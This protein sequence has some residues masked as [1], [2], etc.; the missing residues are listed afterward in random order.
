MTH[1]H[2]RRART[3]AVLLAGAFV[4]AACGDTEPTADEVTETT[5][6]ASDPADEETTEAAAEGSVAFV[7]PEDGATVTSPVAIE[8]SATGVEVQPAAQ[9]VEGAGHLHVMVD[10]DCLPEGEVI[11][12][13]EQHVHF[14]DGSLT[15]ELELEAGEHT[16]CLQYADNDHI[17]TAITSTIT[18]TVE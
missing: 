9:L 16:L 15:G 13:D 1:L 3:A 11:P 12:A 2:S 18:I 14:G 6:A 17:A 8:M 4:L 10:T 5:E 7:A